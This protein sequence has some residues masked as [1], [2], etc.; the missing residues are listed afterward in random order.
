MQEGT[1][2]LDRWEAAR[3]GGKRALRG[4]RDPVSPGHSP[5]FEG[6]SFFLEL[7]SL[8]QGPLVPWECLGSALLAVRG[9]GGPRDLFPRDLL[10]AL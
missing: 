1:G 5:H 2:L 3:V 10:N 8:Q 4:R 7:S 9:A 6:F